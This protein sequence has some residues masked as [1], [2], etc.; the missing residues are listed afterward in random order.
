MVDFAPVKV[1]VDDNLKV[2]SER[3][4]LSDADQAFETTSSQSSCAT[5]VSIYSQ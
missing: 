3:D 1:E 4:H 5:S 2:C